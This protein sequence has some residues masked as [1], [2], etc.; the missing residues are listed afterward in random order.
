MFGSPLIVLKC[1][2]HNR[3]SEQIWFEQNAKYENKIYAHDKR[4]NIRGDFEELN[5]DAESE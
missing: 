4:Q 5:F 3:M 2:L 1:A